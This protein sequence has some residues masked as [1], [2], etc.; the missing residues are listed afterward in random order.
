MSA[1]ESVLNRI[2]TYRDT[3]IDWQKNLVSIKA[4]GP[5][6]GGDGELEKSKYVR[7]ILDDIGF[8]E[9]N[10]INAPDER[11]SSK[12]RPNFLAKIFGQHR[13]KT[14]WIMAHMDVVP[15]GDLKHWHSDPFEL[16]VD[17]DKLIGRGVEDNHQGL[18]CSLLAAKAIREEKLTPQYNIGLAIVADEEC[19]SKFG[20]EYLLNNHRDEFG[21]HDLIIVPDAG[22]PVGNTIEVSEKSILWIQFSIKGKQCH[23]STPQHG[24]NAHRAAAHLAVEL[25]KLYEIFPDQDDLYDPPYSTFEPTKKEANV[26]NINT[27]PAEDVFCLDCRILPTY[28]FEQVDETIQKMVDGIKDKFKVEIDLTYPQ[29]EEA[30]PPTAADAPVVQALAS[31]IKSV[32]NLEPEIVG[33]GG[34]TVAA[35]FRHAG[36][37]AA[38]WGTIEDT[39]H[40]PNEYA[41]ISNT[42]EDAKILATIFLS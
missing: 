13:D 14:V 33:I 28:S 11:V 38:V 23:A 18:V 17:G 40:Q 36:L 15:E 22:E 26:P 16:V 24:I 21:D 34:G 20:L 31:A 41:L 2:E 8:D 12:I 35:Y 32:K 7:T 4:L 39:C 27:I 42:L 10:V 30:A 37:P 3:V 6:N 29:R 9:I 5:E 19:G 1:I 25:D